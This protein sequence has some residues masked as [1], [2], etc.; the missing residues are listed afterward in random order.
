M[1]KLNIRA[2]A[3]ISL[4]FLLIILIVT[5]IGIEYTDHVLDYRQKETDG[6]NPLFLFLRIHAISG[7]L[8]CVFSIVHIVLNWKAMKG[9]IKNIGKNLNKKM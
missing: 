2:F 8:F 7:Y 5:T 1:K 3:S 4:F 6:V 9:Y